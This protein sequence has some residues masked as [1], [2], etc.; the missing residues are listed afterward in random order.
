VTRTERS[1]V[2]G[3][4]GFI[5]RHLVERLISAGS[6]VLIVD[7][8]PGSGLPGGV[9]AITADL[10]DLEMAR[11]LQS[12]RP[13]LVFHLAN[14]ASVPPSF[15][16][17][18]E[19]LGLNAMTT[20]GV[21]ETVR[22][23]QPRPAVVFVSSAAVYGDSRTVPM[24]EDHPLRPI[25]PYGIS[26]LAAEH[27]VRL[28][29]STHGVAACSVRP[30][31][32]YGPGQRKQVVY[33]LMRRLIDG[34]DP[35]VVRASGA[36]SRDF[37]WVKDAVDCLIRLAVAA[38]K[39]GE[40]YNIATGNEVTL[41]ELVDIIVQTVGRPVEVRFTGESRAGDPVRWVGDPTRAA[42]VGAVCE[43]P[44]RDGLRSTFDW[45]SHEP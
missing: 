17:P 25:S 36:V 9:E 13:D 40:A 1:L 26:K 14:S 20:I 34:E 12:Y 39:Q 18:R 7:R 3:G 22:H 43:M 5:G 2:L 45:L 10:R 38:P 28:Y 21:L 31:S 35:L 29:A 37:V 44:L 4:A 6:K 19:D 8:N 23:L 24:T 11:A 30:F 16:S 27:Y 33:D 42:G 41:E 32:I 15:E